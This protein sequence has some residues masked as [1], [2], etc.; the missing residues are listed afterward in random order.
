M[1]L[2]LVVEIFVISSLA[3]FLCFLLQNTGSCFLII[4]AYCFYVILFDQLGILRL[5]S[6]FPES[7]EAVAENIALIR[8]SLTAAVLFVA[9]GLISF[10]FR[11][12]FK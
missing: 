9:A 7:A 10:R 12:I 3:Y 8:N 11:R 1:L 4:A 2:Q 6:V 5:L